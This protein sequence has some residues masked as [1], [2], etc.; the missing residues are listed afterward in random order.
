MNEDLEICKNCKKYLP[1][2]ASFCPHCGLKLK[3]SIMAQ[4]VSRICI[5]CKTEI[6]TLKLNYC[7][8]C[9]YD[10]EAPKNI[11]N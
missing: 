11:K 2:N 3:S 7:P 4:K 8:I 10:L 9:N 1:K 6:R 5:K